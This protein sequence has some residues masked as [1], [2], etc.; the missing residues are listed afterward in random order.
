MRGSILLERLAATGEK[1]T[2][3]RPP[4]AT[5]IPAH[6]VVYPKLYCNHKGVRTFRP[7]KHPNASA[8]TNMLAEKPRWRNTLIS[9]IGWSAVS[10][11]IQK[12][13]KPMQATIARTHISSE[14]NQSRSFPSSS[15]ICSAPTQI[16]SKTNPTISIALLTSSSSK[17]FNTDHATTEKAMAIGTLM[18]NTHDQL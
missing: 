5:T 4:Q 1:T 14:A 13:I 12:L 2:C 18:I 7:K 6:V 3:R 10:S 11:Q 9:T 17:I 15:M 16:T 8:S